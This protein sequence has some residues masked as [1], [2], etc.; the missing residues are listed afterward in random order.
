MSLQGQGERESGVKELMDIWGVSLIKMLGIGGDGRPGVWGARPLR[1]GI[2]LSRTHIPPK[3][4]KSL[5]HKRD[6]VAHPITKDGV[7]YVCPL[8][9]F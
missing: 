7:I 8:Q 3:E 2:V 9:A 5:G 6:N 4:D 1:N